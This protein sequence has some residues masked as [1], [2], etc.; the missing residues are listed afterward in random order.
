M[1][2]PATEILSLSRS[3]LPKT[4]PVVNDSVALPPLSMGRPC[5]Q[6]WG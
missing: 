4:V 1:V 6:A 3:D 5:E 2:S